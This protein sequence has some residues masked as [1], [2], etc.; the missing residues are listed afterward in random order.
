[1]ATIS[2]AKLTWQL[3]PV[4]HFMKLHARSRSEQPLTMTVAATPEMDTLL[5][6]P[7][8]SVSPGSGRNCHLPSISVAKTLS[9]L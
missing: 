8:A 5:M 7:S 3:S 9:W 1:M 2:L 6:L 4:Y